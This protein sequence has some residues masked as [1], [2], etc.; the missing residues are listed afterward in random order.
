MQTIQS[1]N[2][3]A[4]LN[5]QKNVTTLITKAFVQIDHVLTNTFASNALVT[6]LQYTVM[7]INKQRNSHRVMYLYC[8]LK[9]C[10][11]DLG[12]SPINI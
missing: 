9:E 4:L 3:P 2:Q 1:L 12:F 5:I 6:T 10:L 11:W 8:Q 7:Q